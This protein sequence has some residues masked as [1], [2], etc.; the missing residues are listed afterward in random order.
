M[1]CCL[2]SHARDFHA[3]SGKNTGSKYALNALSALEA[4]EIIDKFRIA[5]SFVQLEFS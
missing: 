5:N 4:L 2:F 3:R 1:V